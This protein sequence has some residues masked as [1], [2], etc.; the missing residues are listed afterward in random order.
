MK[1]SGAARLLLEL[2]VVLSCASCFSN[3][4]LSCSSNLYCQERFK[5]NE[6]VC[7][8]SGFCSNPFQQGCLKTLHKDFPSHR[9]CKSHPFEQEECLK[10]LR[11]DFPSQRICNSD[12]LKEIANG[13]DSSSNCI[14]S[15]WKYPELRIHHGNWESSM[16]LSWI[17]QIMLM[18][19]VGVPATV[20]LTTD[21]SAKASFYNPI[22]TLEYSA[23]AYPWAAI[24]T[25]NEFDD[26]TLTK[27]P[28]VHVLPEVWSGQRK[29]WLELLQNEAIDPVIANGMVGKISLYIPAFTAK[30]YPTL[31]S[32]YGLQGKENRLLL[33][34]T[35]YRPTTWL[36]Y[37]Q[38][39]SNST[40]STADSTSKEY[41]SPDEE[42]LYF[43]EGM[44]TG[45]FRPN[46]KNDCEK[47]LFCTGH[48]VAFSCQFSTD[49]DSQLY[50]N[51][52]IGLETDGPNDPNGGYDY[53]S[54]VQIW[55]AANATKSNVIMQWSQPDPLE[56]FVGS[57]S[58]FQQVLLPTATNVCLQ[59]RV[60]AEDRCS[61]D[62]MIRRGDPKGACD[63][64]AHA[65]KQVMA[66]SVGE[67]TLSQLEASQSPAFELIKSIKIT[68]FEI[69]A[70][71]NKWIKKGV[72]RSG[73]DAREAVC[74][75]VVENLDNLLDFVPVGYP[76]QRTDD[77]QYDKWFLYLAQVVGALTSC[78]VLTLLTLSFRYRETKVMVYAQP[79]FVRLILIGFLFTSAAAMVIVFEPTTASCTT[80]MWLV[81]LGYSVELVPVLV[82]TAAINHVVHSSI[83]SQQR[84]TMS[85]RRLIG[86]VIV[87]L[88]LVLSFLICWTVI[89]PP[90]RLETLVMSEKD[91]E[92]VE[93]FLRCG[94]DKKVWRL[95]AAAW[96]ALLLFIAAILAFQS[97]NTT[98]HF[99]ES[100]SL[101]KMVYS[102]FLF[103]V[104]RNITLI[105]QLSDTLPSGVTATLLSFNYSLDALIAMSIYLLPKFLEARK[106]PNIYRPGTGS[107][108]SSLNVPREASSYDGS[109]PG[110]PD[111]KLNILTC[112]ANIGNA[113][114]TLESM[115]AWVPMEG[116]CGLVT[117]IEGQSLA[118]GRFG[119]IAIGMQ[120]ATWKPKIYKHQSV[121]QIRGD[122]ISEDEVLNA[123]EAHDTAA[124]R[125]MIQDILG[126]GYIKVAE[127]Q[128]GQMRLHIWALDTVL[129]DITDIK[130]SGANTGI[131][132][133]M[134]NKGGIVVTLNYKK[135]RITFLSAHLEAHE[136]ESY[137]Q[138]RC[139]NIRNILREAK[140]F[141]TSK[142]FDVATSSHHMFVLG[143]LNFRTKFG[144]EH[145]DNVQRAL[146]LIKA[147]D[148]ESLYKFDELH[149]GIEDGDLLVGFE[150]LPCHFP[151]TFK[152][153]RQAGFV[154]MDQRTPSYTD[155]ILFKSAEG[156][157]GNLK[158]LAYE[159][160]VDF[161]TSDH[162]P[163][164]G[165]F[166]IVPNQTITSFSRGS[167]IRLVF[168]NM[169]CSNIP[170]GDSNGSSDPYLMVLWDSVDLASGKTNFW[171]S[172]RQSLY[173]QSWPRTKYL[174]KSLN[175]KWEG[176]EMT[177]I[178]KANSMVGSDAMLFLAVMDFDANSADDFLCSLP[179]NVMDLISMEE[180]DTQKELVFDRPLQK[181]ARLCGRIQFDLQIETRVSLSTRSGFSQGQSNFV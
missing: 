127:Q 2:V 89:D 100:K 28:C 154:Y 178:L 50:W 6:T 142:K 128:R 148:Y 34:E 175:P 113:K 55:R 120:E 8:P 27:E 109:L 117:P 172:F 151:P 140:T 67:T 122:V 141:G 137:Y 51:D 81:V 73:N 126:K 167:D 181:S 35:F 84:V 174:P 24:G 58:E 115:A 170:C 180:G 36:D 158:A 136:G 53:T 40:C 160:C 139:D 138:A 130:I 82:K 13:T 77:N 96:L 135:T 12:D 5:R 146:E 169:Q 157:G 48:V 119:L 123:L 116:A 23:E 11:K 90:T 62:I 15:E 112:T 17:Y 20:G 171:D 91:P 64:E 86:K 144:G 41:P 164:R 134:S 145:E 131:G 37:C 143:D 31:V 87:A 33:A 168:R 105:F 66:T 133:V 45:H 47:S 14:V 103:M 21:D 156:L 153:E 71:F 88:A 10:T 132:N 26:C 85:P 114:P 99:N 110:L 173:G 111:N 18:E 93:V 152:V 118:S 61:Q 49:L 75:W 166:S 101:G 38:Q 155:R 72:D 176:Q 125:E 56:E 163:V 63:S 22:N 70:I 147:E 121:Q 3:A 149:Q 159:P 79:I 165:A 32:F 83:K 7:L 150:T 25:A 42:Q 54:M 78:V 4:A 106:S 80:T 102:H 30:L 46:D 65:L 44:Y 98:Q 124:L 95:T 16:F 43:S 9:T 107:R 68:E 29:D 108:V 104:M 162:K 177:L 52:I 60:G 19:V 57:D 129:E 74:T 39:V 97:R 1:Y 76:K 161:I 179:L 69:H 94:S 92:I 59:N